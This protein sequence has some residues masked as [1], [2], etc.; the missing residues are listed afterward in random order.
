MKKRI[1]F[2]FIP[3]LIVFSCEHKKEGAHFQKENEPQAEKITLIFEKFQ[4]T[5][6]PNINRAIY[7]SDIFDFKINDIRVNN[8]KEND[9][10]DI[11]PK[12]NRICL[13]YAQL[14]MARYYEF[15]RGD[16]V[17]FKFGKRGAPQIAIPNRK[18]LKFDLNLENQT[19]I[20]KPLEDYEF[21]KK[22][23]RVRS[24]V[25]RRQYHEALKTYY[26]S[27]DSL[28]DS[29]KQN[30]MLSQSIYRLNKGRNKYLYFNLLRRKIDFDT[31][32]I[33]NLKQDSLIYFKGYRFF[34]ENYTLGKFGVL[35][36]HNASNARPDYRAIYDSVHQ[37]TLFSQRVKEYLLYNFLLKINSTSSITDFN[38]Y[39]QRFKKSVRDTAIVQYVEDMYLLDFTALKSSTE[40]AHFIDPSR[41]KITFDRLLKENRGKLV[42]IDFWASWCAPCRAAM[43]S[44]KKLRKEYNN[45]NMVFIYISIDKDYNQ[46]VKAMED[47]GLNMNSNNFL[48]LNYPGSKMYEKL[49]LSTIP[50]YLL[51]DENG[52]LVHQ[53]APGPSD[54]QIRSLL[55]EYLQ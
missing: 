19:P 50:R 17:V 27:V 55:D 11:T 4:D 6:N 36:G 39:F 12:H 22:Y 18:T 9:T 31:L 40:K 20:K 52:E 47:D 38:E 13:A 14:P 26:E 48:A 21:Y 15:Q 25:D 32:G 46:W 5:I 43:P 53:N 51:Y 24:E 35:K 30:Q 54:G 16:T 29:L 8:T 1:S 2:L 45:E 41:R 23:N 42:Y 37:S 3:I 7:Y 28:L 44:A 10:I 33:E 49:K 34:L